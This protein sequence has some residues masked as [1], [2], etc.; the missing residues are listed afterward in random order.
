MEKYS[1]YTAITDV[2]KTGSITLRDN[3]NKYDDIMII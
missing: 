3:I 2:V 1:L